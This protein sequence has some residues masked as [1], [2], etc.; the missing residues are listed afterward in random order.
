MLSVLA[1]LVKKEK[2]KQTQNSNNKN[3][4][5]Y[6][7]KNLLIVPNSQNSPCLPQ[8]PGK[9]F[10][11]SP[12]LNPPKQDLHFFFPLKKCESLFWVFWG[13]KVT[14]LLWPAGVSL[15]WIR[16]KVGVY[17]VLRLSPLGGSPKFQANSRLN[18]ETLES[19]TTLLAYFVC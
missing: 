15:R 13:R 2:Q 16:L 12:I 11:T 5:N 7:C 19:P 3:K 4:Q 10:S 9:M 17:F 6:L 18:L 8:K 14:L 1:F